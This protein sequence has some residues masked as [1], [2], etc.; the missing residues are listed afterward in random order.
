M[1]LI[2]KMELK[3]SR[4]KKANKKDLRRGPIGDGMETRRA[5]Q[6]RRIL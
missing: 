6:R 3:R 5:V 2:L 4:Q 1:E